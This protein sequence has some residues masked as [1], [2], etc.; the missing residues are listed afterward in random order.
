MKRVCEVGTDRGVQSATPIPTSGSGAWRPS[1]D[2]RG[3][4]RRRWKGSIGG[5]KQNG[6]RVL[7]GI[8]D[9]E[10]FRVAME[11]DRLAKSRSKRATQN[12]V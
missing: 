1:K 9:W 7:P 12:G 10:L 2:E 4:R 6:A 11:L 5:G 8:H 3:R